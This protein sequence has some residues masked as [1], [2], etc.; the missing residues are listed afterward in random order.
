LHHEISVAAAVGDE[1][2]MVE[3]DEFLFEQ[4]KLHLLQNA[5]IAFNV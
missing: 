5:T 3:A 1:E 2:R 4:K